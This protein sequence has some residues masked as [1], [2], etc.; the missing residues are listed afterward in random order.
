MTQTEMILEHM[1]K[2]G[3]ITQADA[4]RLFG[5]YRLGARVYDLKERGIDVQK[6]MVPG[7]N[8]YGK[9]TRYARYFLNDV[10]DQTA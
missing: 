4:I 7:V 10:A 8:R 9:R 5:C 1:Q 3:G 2:N 6:T